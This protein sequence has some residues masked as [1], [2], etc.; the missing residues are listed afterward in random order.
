MNGPRTSP[1]YSPTYVDAQLASPRVPVTIVI[2]AFNEECNLGPCI[3]SCAFSDD[4]HLLDSGSTDRSASVAKAHGA[5]VWTNKFVSFAAQ[6]NWAIDHLPHKYDWVFHL[7]ADERFTPGIVNEMRELIARNPSEAGFYV[8]NRLIF[9]GRWLRYA[10]GYPVY[11]VRLFHRQRLRFQPHGH[12][13][14]ELTTGAVGTLREPYLHFN[15]SKGLDDWFEKH[16]RYS[17]QEAQQALAERTHKLRLSELM[18]GD[19][20]KRR[21]AMKSLAYRLP[22]R[23]TLRWLHTMLTQRAVLDGPPGWMYA[24]LLAIYEKMTDLKLKE[25]RLN[26]NGQRPERRIHE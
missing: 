13:Q 22:F 10:S 20:I 16:N 4:I 14:R 15:F 12:S 9:M 17:T 24:R 7:D 21:R 3:R 25:L 11:Q 23:P 19:K 18:S 6:R 5:Q 1:A 8:P 26:A 2:L